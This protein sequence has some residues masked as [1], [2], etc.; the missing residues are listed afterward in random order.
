MSEPNVTITIDIPFSRLDD[1]LAALKQAVPPPEISAELK[2]D[3][4]PQDPGKKK[5][6]KKRKLSLKPRNCEACEKEY[7]PTGPRQKRCPECIELDRTLDQ[8]QSKKQEPYKF[9]K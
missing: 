1:I 2:A 8:I 6:R 7:Q 3:P 4:P 9:S 5:P